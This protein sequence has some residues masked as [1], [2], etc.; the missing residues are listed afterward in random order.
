MTTSRIWKEKKVIKSLKEELE[1]NK[2]TYDKNI[3]LLNIR[4]ELEKS[5]LDD[6]N[7]EQK[8]YN[9]TRDIIEIE[10]KNYK[11]VTPLMEFHRVR[12]WQEKWKELKEFEKENNERNYKIAQK[13]FEVQKKR[14]EVNIDIDKIKEQQTRIDEKT[15][16]ILEQLKK[17]GVNEEEK[18][19]KIE[20]TG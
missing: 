11:V 20:Y 15:P 9:L 3:E 19:D 4:L 6:F 13:N 5:N 7:F 2:K 12:D 17:F 18:T 14:I 10:L 8:K 16:T 1:Q